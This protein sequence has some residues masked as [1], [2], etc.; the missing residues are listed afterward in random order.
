[1]TALYAAVKPQRQA[2]VLYRR[3]FYPSLLDSFV[4]QSKDLSI[5]LLVCGST[6]VEDR[7]PTS[8]PEA[9]NLQRRDLCYI[10]IEW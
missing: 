5:C 7:L 8:D 9:K 10:A 2:T 6:S 3:S 4:G 1:M